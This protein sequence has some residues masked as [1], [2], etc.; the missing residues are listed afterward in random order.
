MFDRTHFVRLQVLSAVIAFTAAAGILP[1]WSASDTAVAQCEVAKLAASDA[2]EQDAD[3][4]AR[5][6][7]GP[8]QL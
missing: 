4:W 3:P 1:V 5:R 2:A 8:P 7:T 6:A